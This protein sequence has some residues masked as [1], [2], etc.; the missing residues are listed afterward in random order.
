VVLV[1]QP[2]L[3]YLAAQWTVTPVYGWQ[4]GD[5]RRPPLLHD[6]AECPPV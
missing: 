2:V 3:E 5:W 6:P 4:Q 1:G